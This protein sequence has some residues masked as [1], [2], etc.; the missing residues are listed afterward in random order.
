MVMSGRFALVRDSLVMDDLWRSRGHG[1]IAQATPLS[2]GK[3]DV[4]DKRIIVKQCF[5][6][7]FYNFARLSGPV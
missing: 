5:G 1:C 3:V 6:A 7:T 2:I 4:P